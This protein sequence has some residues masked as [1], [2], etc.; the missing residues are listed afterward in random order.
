MCEKCFSKTDVHLHH[1]IP[2]KT[3]GTNDYDN[4]IPLCEECHWEFHRHF[5]AVKSHEYFMGT[6]K[7]TELIGL[8]EVVNDPLVDSLFMKEFKE[9]V[10]KGLDLKRDVQKSF[11]EEEIEAN[12]EELK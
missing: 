7:Y 3:G 2:L 5:E 9:L 8:W 4:L 12:K 1:K 10:Y 11:N 6:P